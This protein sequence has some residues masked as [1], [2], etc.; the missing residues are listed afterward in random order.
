MLVRPAI[1]LTNALSSSQGGKETF[2]YVQLDNFCLSGTIVAVE[3][4]VQN[5]FISIFPNPTTAEFVL[6]FTGSIPKAGIVQIN[7]LYG[8]IVF[9]EK[10]LSG[11]ERHSF[12]IEHLPPGL[13]FVNVVENGIPLWHDK[14]IKE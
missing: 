4:P 9:S 1:Y 11:E 14:I 3:E 8:R 13:Y 6:Q 10:I 12:T 5:N 7:D 2:T